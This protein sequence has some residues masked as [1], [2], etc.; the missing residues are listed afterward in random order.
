M[1]D[2]TVA[3]GFANSLSHF[4]N[5]SPTRQGCNDRAVVHIAQARLQEDIVSPQ[6]KP[7]LEH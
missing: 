1:E 7:M 6:R 5:A 2:P 4:L 3:T